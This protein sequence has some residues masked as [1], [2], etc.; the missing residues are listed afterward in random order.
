MYVPHFDMPDNSVTAVNN[1]TDVTAS[2]LIH[3]SDT[4]A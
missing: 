4:V 2:L 1:G 3:L